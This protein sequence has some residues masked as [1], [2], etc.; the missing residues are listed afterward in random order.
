MTLKLSCRMWILNGNLST[1]NCQPRCFAL[2]PIQQFF[3]VRISS[4]FRV[5]RRISRFDNLF[6]S[7]DRGETFQFYYGEM[8]TFMIPVCETNLQI[9]IML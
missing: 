6:R 4:D 5:N 7:G 3:S 2:I 8:G 1:K 9:H